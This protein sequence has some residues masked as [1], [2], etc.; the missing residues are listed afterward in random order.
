M[1][2]GI[3]EGT[4]KIIERTESSLLFS[5]P[6]S[7][8][9]KIGDSLAV[10]GTCL[11]AIALQDGTMKADIL[12]ETWKRTNLGDLTPG[13]LVN[14]ER[15]AKIGGSLDGHMVQGH[16]DGV[17]EFWSVE[18][19]QFGHKVFI[20]VPETLTKYMVEKGSIA[21]DGI[22]LTLIDVRPDAFSFE[23]IPHTWEVTN[24]HARKT[25]DKMNIEVDVLA[26]YVEKLIDRK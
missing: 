19:S 5:Y 13:D 18:E 21:V 11:T 24:L 14:L 4:G 8:S 9:L 16:V 25:G 2:T 22:S 6:D 12:E 23:A 7:I 3:I 20:R 1:F 15:P 17:G 26:K 10:N